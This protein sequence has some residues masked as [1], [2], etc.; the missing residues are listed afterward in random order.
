MGVWDSC[1]ADGAEG[2]V[3]MSHVRTQIRAAAKAWMEEITPGKVFGRVHPLKPGTFPG[4]CVFFDEE[5]GSPDGAPNGATMRQMTLV[6]EPHVEGFDSDDDLDALALQVEQQVFA[7]PTFGGVAMLGS[8]YEGARVESGPATQQMQY[9]KLR[10]Q[11]V[12]I[13]RTKDGDPEHG[14]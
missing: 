1:F 2:E 11:W 12:V 9:S 5:A 4:I 10:M 7:D 6:I 3:G 13:Y 14:I 8:V